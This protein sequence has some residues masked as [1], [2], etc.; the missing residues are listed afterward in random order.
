MLKDFLDYPWVTSPFR[1]SS[2]DE[3]ISFFESEVI[4]TMGLA[5]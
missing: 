5:R 2:V 1:Y 4:A 3:L